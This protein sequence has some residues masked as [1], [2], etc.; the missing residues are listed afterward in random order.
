MT[1]MTRAAAGVSALDAI[2]WSFLRSE[3]AEQIYAGWTIER[4]LDAYLLHHGPAALLKDGSACDELL[5]RV[6]A[7]I[8]AALR[9]GVLREP[10]A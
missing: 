4:R 8:A 7:N 1:P 9:K 6:M 2:A 3:F 5:E 10:T